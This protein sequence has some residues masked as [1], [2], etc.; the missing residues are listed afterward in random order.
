MTLTKTIIKVKNPD[1][2]IPHRGEELVRE[3]RIK[4]KI[5]EHMKLV[6]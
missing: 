5:I 1:A 6:N 3:P 4:E 2:R